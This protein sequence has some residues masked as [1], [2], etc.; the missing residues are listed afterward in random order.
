MVLILGQE[1]QTSIKY[2]SFCQPEFEAEIFSAKRVIFLIQCNA[3]K[4]IHLNLSN[5]KTGMPYRHELEILKTDAAAY[6]VLYL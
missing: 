2:F 3:T 6:E 5:L 1:E 4:P